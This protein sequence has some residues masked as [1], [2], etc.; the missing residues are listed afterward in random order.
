M[1]VVPITRKAQALTDVIFGLIA[2][3]RA[4]SG[5]V[6][7]GMAYVSRPDITVGWLPLAG[8]FRLSTVHERA[9]RRFPPFVGGFQRKK[10]PESNA[11][12]PAFPFSFADGYQ[13]PLP[14]VEVGAGQ[15]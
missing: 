10:R 2:Q 11:G 1:G 13:R 6:R 12:V 8:G 4:G 9:Y 5:D 7:Q 14:G 3:Q 15:S